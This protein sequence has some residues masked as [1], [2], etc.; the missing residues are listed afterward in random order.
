MECFPTTLARM[1]FSEEI[2][3]G[4]KFRVQLKPQDDKTVYM[5]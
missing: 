4:F 1:V 3:F 5:Q 2:K